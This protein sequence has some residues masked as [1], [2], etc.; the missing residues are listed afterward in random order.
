MST[1]P[2]QWDKIGSEPAP[3]PRGEPSAIQAAPTDDRPKV[4][5]SEDKVVRAVTDSEKTG[6]AR[7]TAGAP[8][9]TPEEIAEELAK[10]WSRRRVDD[11]HRE[12]GG[13][14]GA[15]KHEDVLNDGWP[16][17]LPAAIYGLAG[18]VVRTIEPH[19]EA[20]PAAILIQ[21]L[22]AVGNLLGPGLHCSVESTRH[23]LS[24]YP[25]LVGES[26]KARKGTSWGHIARLCARVDPLWARERVTTGL[27]S[28]EGLICE[29]RDDAD[30]P[31]DR[32]LLIVQS[33]YASVLR[34]MAREG[35]TLSPL[36]RAAWDSGN[37]RTLTKNSPL[38][39]TGAHICVIGH[40]TRPELLRYLSDTEGHNG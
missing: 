8:S 10:P 1:P 2:P 7:L 11:D 23:A 17:L 33:E 6:T 13:D 38:R 18:D 26:S 31:C 15:P 29:V 14:R 35:N 30:P 12:G 25:V 27:S 20:D 3:N 34:V 40:I 21:V 37:L 9:L 28:A 39:S 5:V 19:S 22:T 16:V 24:L 4:P 36:L 32:R